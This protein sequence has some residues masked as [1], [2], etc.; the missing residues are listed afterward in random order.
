MTLVVLFGSF[1]V[2][3][4]LGVPIAISLALA[5]VALLSITADYATYMIAQRMFAALDSSALVAI[6]G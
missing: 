1:V 3:L 2:L 5:S 4:L 6:P